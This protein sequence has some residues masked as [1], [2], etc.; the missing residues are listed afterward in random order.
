MLAEKSHRTKQRAPRGRT[1]TRI[2]AK[3]NLI[4]IKSMVY[5]IM[6]AEKVLSEVASE[7]E[8]PKLSAADASLYRLRK[9]YKELDSGKQQD[10]QRVH[11]ELNSAVNNYV[12]L[13]YSLNFESR[14]R[15]SYECERLRLPKNSIVSF[16]IENPYGKHDCAALMCAHLYVQPLRSMHAAFSEA[17][18]MLSL[19]K[20]FGMRGMHSEA[21][22]SLALNNKRLKSYIAKAE[23]GGLNVLELEQKKEEFA[24][25][26]AKISAENDLGITDLALHRLDP[27]TLSEMN[28]KRLSRR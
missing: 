21:I 2:L 25:K 19:Q 9:L 22:N 13:I 12:R 7:K 14:T 24:S 3:A 17:E 10:M 15:V 5:T 26:F 27:G 23:G 20:A 4:P 11:S 8:I 16:P 18:K 1:E 6:F 28:A